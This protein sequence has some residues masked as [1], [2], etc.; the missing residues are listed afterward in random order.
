MDEQPINWSSFR[1]RIMI[2][3]PVE[4]VYAAWAIPE[5]LATWFLEKAVYTDSN[6]QP[7]KPNEPVRKG[8]RY[9]WKWNNWNAE[10]QG[11]IMEANGKDRLTFSFGLG[12]DVY[13]TLKESDGKTE[14]IL[15]QDGI[16]TD[17]K[18]KKNY[19]VGCST[20]WSFWLANLKAW[21]EHGIT[22]HATGLSQEETADL[23][24]S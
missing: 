13:L 10:E 11:E 21:M 8:D 6:L 7:R 17:E 22:L 24:N 18:S 1:K 16:G 23:V 4:D 9:T 2:S 19:Y 20:G 12:G 5:K 15:V 3:R 14:V